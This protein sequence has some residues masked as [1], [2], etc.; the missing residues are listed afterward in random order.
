MYFIVQGTVD[1]IVKGKV[2][3]QLQSGAFFGELALLGN[4]PRTAT[5]KATSACSMYRLYREHFMKII[6]NFSD[7]KYRIQMIFE[8]RMQKVER[9]KSIQ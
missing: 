8:E 1:I 6:D 2:V 3:G 4:I 5:I 9:E 7:V